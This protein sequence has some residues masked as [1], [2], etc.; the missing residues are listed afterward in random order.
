MTTS[1]WLILI[2]ALVAGIFGV[3]NLFVNYSIKR[4]VSHEEKDDEEKRKLR[5]K[6]HDRM[7]EIEDNYLESYLYDKRLGKRLTMIANRIKIY[8]PELASLIKRYKKSWRDR[9]S[10]K[11]STTGVNLADVYLAVYRQEHE[12]TIGYIHDRADFLTKNYTILDIIKVRYGWIK[13]R[14]S[15]MWSNIQERRRQKEKA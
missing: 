4:R 2:A 3:I 10:L 1:D 14:T 6:I 11:K 8:D 7:S 12:D 13:F 5:I 15:L 9:F